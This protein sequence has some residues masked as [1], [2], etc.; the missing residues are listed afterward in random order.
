MAVL[1]RSSE[2]MKATAQAGITYFT[3]GLAEETGEVC[4][5]VKKLVRA[6]NGL[7]KPKTY[8]KVKA[9]LEKQLANINAE[10]I[11]LGAKPLPFYVEDEE[12]REVYKN[13]LLDNLEIEIGQVVQYLANIAYFYNL[14]LG[15]VVKKS[16]NHTSKEFNSDIEL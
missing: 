16:F 14:D 10:K 15:K 3:T 8:D 13:Q 11:K 2:A 9:E 5:A 7:I 12:V 6:Q 1:I 4:G